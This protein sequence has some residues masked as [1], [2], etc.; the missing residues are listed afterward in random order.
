MMFTGCLRF[1]HKQVQKP[2]YEGDLLVL[3]LNMGILF[4][5]A[6]YVMQSPR[7]TPYVTKEIKYSKPQKV[8]PQRQAKP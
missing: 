5:Q 4:L 7:E 8:V 6:R 1:V 2:Y 3:H